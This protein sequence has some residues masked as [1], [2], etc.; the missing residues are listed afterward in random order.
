MTR[1]LFGLTLLI[2]CAPVLAGL[3][4]AQTDPVHTAQVYTVQ[5]G[6]TLYRIAAAHGFTVA[7]LAAYN[8]L[9]DPGRLEV[10][11][12][13][14]LPGAPGAPELRAPFTGL[15][16]EPE[17]PVQGRSFAVEVG[18]E[19]PAALSARFLDWDY[20]LAIAPDGARGVLAVPALQEPGVYP[21]V[22]RAPGGAVLEVPVR[23]ASGDY[24]RE[25][26]TL[27]PAA[28]NLLQRD[29]IREELAY[30]R[31]RCRPFEEAP[32]WSGAFRLPLDNPVITS[33][34]GTRRSYNGGPYSSYHEGL[35]FRGNA[36]TPVY[37]AADGRVVI[38]EALTV[39][40]N[41]VYLLHGMSVCTGYTH[42][43]RLTVAPGQEV[44][45]G[46]LL[47]YVGMTGLATGPHLHWEIRVREI[48]VDPTPWLSAPPF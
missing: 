13:L 45:Q 15:R 22:L 42:L 19:A 31:A 5:P 12:V 11:Q 39:R 47:G 27:P 30:V 28:S 14:R 21:L 33:G 35:D 32:R 36:S 9:G 23:V 1:R 48:P 37:A 20:E 2:L 41:A 18:L 46:D 8:A 40:G 26:I 25:S 16:L 24:A 7:E 6:D 43:D 38:A 3:G 4:A 34:F 17:R 10:G 44:R 29:L